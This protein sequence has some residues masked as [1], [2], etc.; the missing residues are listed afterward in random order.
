MSFPD[1]PASSEAEVM[2]MVVGGCLSLDS[3]KNGLSASVFSIP[4]EEASTI[5]APSGVW[6]LLFVMGADSSCAATV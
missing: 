1:A 6:S 3:L 4:E 2:V 5:A